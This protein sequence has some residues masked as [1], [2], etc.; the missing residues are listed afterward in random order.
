MIVAIAGATGLTGGLCLHRLLATP[1]VDKII[2]IGRRPTGVQ[3]EKIKEVILVNGQLTESITAD[4]F[5]CCLGTTI[6]KAGSQKAFAEVDYELPLYLAKMLH[7]SGCQTAA[8]ISS[9]GANPTSP[10]FYNRTKGQME[11]NMRNIG[12]DSLA[13]LRPSIISGHRKETRIGEKLGVGLMK[14]TGPLLQG[15][16]KNFRAIKASNIAAALVKAIKNPKP[17]TTVYL[18]EKVKKLAKA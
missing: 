11:E 5:I 6:A 9:M 2:A 13:L 15:R 14:I 3:H 16:F 1:E 7:H 10:I 18:S 12:F 17:G 8:I 4:A